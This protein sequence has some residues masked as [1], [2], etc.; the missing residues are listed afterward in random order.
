MS[1]GSSCAA[2][3]RWPISSMLRSITVPP[4]SGWPTSP[5]RAL[6]SCKA[7]GLLLQNGQPHGD[8]KPVDEVLAVGVQIL[9]HLPHIPT[10]VG[11]E[12]HLLVLLHPLGFPHFPQAPPRLP[13]IALHEAKALRRRHRVGFRPP[14][15]HHSPAGDHLETTLLMGRTQGIDLAGQW[16]H[17][18]VGESR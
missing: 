4:L 12:D 10:T 11:P 3:K 2:S 5:K 17:H 16:C 8:G 9:L 14:G 18:R 13:V 6:T 7:F 15:C 1:A